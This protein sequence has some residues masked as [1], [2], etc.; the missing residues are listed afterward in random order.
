SN[1]GD[2]VFA[3]SGD[4]DI[5]DARDLARRYIG[6]LFGAEQTEQYKDFQVDPPS[7]IVT[8]EVHAGTGDKG[9]LT[10]DWNAPSDDPETESVYADVL[11]SVLNIRLTDHIREELGASYSPSAYVAI[12]TEPDQRVESF[13]NV[14]GDPATIPQISKIV[15]DDVTALH[16]TGPRPDEFDAAIA[17]LTETYSYFDNQ[18]IVDLIARAPDA[19]ELIS[20]F[21]HRSTVLEDITGVTLQRFVSQVMP[22]DRYIEVRTVPA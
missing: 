4:F 2:W 18:T 6:T 5:G 15:I 20:R 12:N 3:L 10:F 8:K 16:A 13:L 14:T 11:T 19:P 1:V 7:T 9:S 17:E 21:K 22:L